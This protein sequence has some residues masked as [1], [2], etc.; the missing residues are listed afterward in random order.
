MKATTNQLGLF[1]TQ[2]RPPVVV[3]YGMG[4]D[5][6]AMLVGMAARGER[7]DLILFAD[8]G[9]E[10]PE[11]YAYLPTIQAWLKKVG[12]PPVQVVRYTP[13]KF[14]NAPY[15]TLEGNCLANRTLPSLAFGRKGCSLKWKRA[16]QDKFCRTWAPARE[17]WDAGGKVTKLIGYD[18]GPA[19]SRRAI[20]LTEDAEYTYRYP[21]RE[22]GW[23]REECKRQI[24]AAGLP[25]PVKSACFFCPATKPAELDEMMAT[26][27][28]LVDRIMEMEATAKPHLRNVDGLWRKAVKG[29]R[30][31]QARPGSMTEYIQA[32][33]AT[34]QVLQDDACAGCF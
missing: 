16:P 14:K 21:L 30:G 9:S 6:T 10:K 3:A 23:E 22:W 25:L 4:V 15:S 17:C 1:G 12:F 2:A 28:E 34:L 27:P 8:T 11:T 7:P 18:A 31:G 19:D 5:S 20:N 13:T 24:L 32:K 33:R 29:T 26:H